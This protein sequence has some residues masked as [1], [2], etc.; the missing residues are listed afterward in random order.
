MNTHKAFI[1]ESPHGVLY[2]DV[3]CYDCGRYLYANLKKADAQKRARA[4][5]WG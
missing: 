5:K 1:V 2:W 4:H 3:Y